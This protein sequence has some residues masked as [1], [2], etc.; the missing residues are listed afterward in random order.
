MKPSSQRRLR[1]TLL[2]GATASALILTGCAA[3]NTPASSSSKGLGNSIVFASYGGSFT[4]AQTNAFYQPFAT[5]NGLKMTVATGVGY[6]KLKA[7][8]KAGNV[9]WD[10]ITADDGNFPADSNAG[11]L[12]P[13]DTKV[14][15]TSNIEKDVVNKYGVGYIKFSQ[16]FGYSKDA[17]PG[18]TMTP[19]DFFDPS[20]KARRTLSSSPQGTLEFALLADGV[21]PSKLYPLDLDRAFKVLDRIKPQL[22]GSTGAQQ[23]TLVQQKEAD[24][25]FMAGGR[26]QDTINAGSN[27]VLSWKD[28]VSQTE[29]WAV[30][31]NAPHKAAAMAFI[32]YALQAQPQAELAALIPYGPTNS[33]AIPLISQAIAKTLPSYPANAAQGVTLNAAYWDEEP[34]SDHR[35]LERLARRMSSPRSVRGRVRKARGPA[36]AGPRPR[37]PGRRVLLPHGV[38]SSAVPCWVR[39][40]LCKR[41]LPQGRAHHGSSGGG[42]HRGHVRGQLSVRVAHRPL[43]RNPPCDPFGNCVHSVPD[44]PVGEDFLLGGCARSDGRGEWCVDVPSGSFT[45]RCRCCLPRERSWLHSFRSPFRSWFSL[46]SVLCRGSIR[47]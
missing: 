5:K 46:W 29:Y 36:S 14:V 3:G 43:L 45:P 31:K 17:F 24:M 1:A 27:W 33:K 37:P 15:N 25:A 20:V 10:V 44:E 26:L 34:Q 40:V 4:D 42:D 6:P 8:E 30:P 21:S 12:A 9:T 19:A 23:E 47:G 2:A 39:R 41:C 38:H 18:K 28:A 35:T 22:V 13:L 16:N 32:N 7:M 11:L